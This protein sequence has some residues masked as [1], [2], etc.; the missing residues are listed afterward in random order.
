MDERTS[1]EKECI[2]LADAT[3]NRMYG[4]RG[5]S[6]VAMS[7]RG[8][9]V[10]THPSGAVHGMEGWSLAVSCTGSTLPQLPSCVTATLDAVHVA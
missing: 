7:P 10:A 4:A 8:L 2:E 5:E 3:N 9:E 1:I 6:A